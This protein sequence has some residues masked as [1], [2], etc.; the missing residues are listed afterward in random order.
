MPRTNKSR[1][2]SD[3]WRLHISKFH[4]ANR[5]AKKAVRTKNRSSQ[6]DET[7]FQKMDNEIQHH[8]HRI[9][10]FNNWERS[11]FGELELNDAKV[12]EYFEDIDEEFKYTDM[13]DNLYFLEEKYKKITN[14]PVQ[15]RTIHLASSTTSISRNHR[16]I[17]AIIKQIE[18]RG[19]VGAFKGHN[20][21]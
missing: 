6:V 3:K 16:E 12:R 8:K 4:N 13:M 10:K 9:R 20:K 2:R 5:K 15:D 7:T 18:R 1:S 14:T 17:S 11:N 21:K 19:K